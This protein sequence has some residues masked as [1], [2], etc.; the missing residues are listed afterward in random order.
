MEMPGYVPNTLNR[1]QHTPKLSP[2][3]SPHHHTG[4][5]YCTPG[6]RQY[7][8]AQDETPTLSKQDTTFVKY[9]AGSFFYYERSIDGTIIPALNEISMQQYKPTQQKK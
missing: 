9:I 6:K 3:Y 1:L 7:A 2:Q 4:F 5:K 8:M